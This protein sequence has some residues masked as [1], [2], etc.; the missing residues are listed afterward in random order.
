MPE[1]MTVTE[2]Q[3]KFL[4]EINELPDEVIENLLQMVKILK[5]TLNHQLAIE[6]MHWNSLIPTF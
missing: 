2:H 3:R 5:R 4:D 6:N 1:L